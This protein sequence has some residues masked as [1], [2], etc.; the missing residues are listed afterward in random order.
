MPATD[1]RTTLDAE[2]TDLLDALASAR[3]ALTRTVDGRKSG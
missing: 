3:A 1:T 2:R